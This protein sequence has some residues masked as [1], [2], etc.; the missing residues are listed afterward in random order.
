M[1]YFPQ[2]EDMKYRECLERK[3]GVQGGLA[4]LAD[5]CLTSLSTGK[6]EP[7]NSTLRNYAG[8]FWKWAKI[9]FQAYSKLHF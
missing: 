8:M 5:C 2:V 6:S 9:C 3:V 4:R 1:L 7:G